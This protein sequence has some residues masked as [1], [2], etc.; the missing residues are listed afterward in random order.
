[1]VFPPDA[2]ITIKSG[3]SGSDQLINRRGEVVRLGPGSMKIISRDFFDFEVDT[4]R[5]FTI[6]AYEIVSSRSKVRRQ[7]SPA[8]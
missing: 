6:S 5:D 7:L 8:A 4:L 2:E 3:S 1:M